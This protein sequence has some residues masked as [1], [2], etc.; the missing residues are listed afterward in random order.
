MIENQLENQLGEA[1]NINSG[2][3]GGSGGGGGSGT[4]IL[5]IVIVVVVLA[6]GGGALWAYRRNQRSTGDSPD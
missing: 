5:I 3:S 6:G 2:T 4:L 1:K